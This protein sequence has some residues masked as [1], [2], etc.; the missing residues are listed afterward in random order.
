MLLALIEQR[1]S[2]EITL[3]LPGT[4]DDTA[5]KDFIVTLAADLNT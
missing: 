1:K 5:V 3:L 4:H 2:L